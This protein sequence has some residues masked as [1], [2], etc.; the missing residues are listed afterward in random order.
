MFCKNCGKEIDEKAVVCLHCGVAV[1]GSYL[2]DKP[3]TGLNVL[4]FFIPIVGL[5]LSVTTKKTKP[6]KAKSLLNWSLAGVGF[7]VVCY[8]L[9]GLL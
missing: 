6:K 5:I 4:A 7:N 3:S 9:A 8:I 2:E 1:Q